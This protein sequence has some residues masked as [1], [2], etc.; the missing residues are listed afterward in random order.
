M[1]RSVLHDHNLTFSA[2]CVYAELALHVYQG[3]TARIG[4]RRLAKLLGASRNT[5]AD[6]LA[7]LAKAGHIVIAGSGKDRRTYHLTSK[8]FGRKQRALDAGEGGEE[9]LVSAPWQG[10]RL[11][12]VRKT[13]RERQMDVSG[14]TAAWAKVQAEREREAG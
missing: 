1:V 13:K 11:A 4:E 5:V 9:E 7:E 10:R 12:T 8:V 6:G 3:T 2:R 14:L